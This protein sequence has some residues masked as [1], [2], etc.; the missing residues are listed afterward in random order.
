MHVERRWRSGQGL[1]L[2]T[3]LAS[4]S[5]TGS[6]AWLAWKSSSTIIG[7]VFSRLTEAEQFILSRDGC[8]KLE[9]GLEIYRIV[10]LRKHG[11]KTTPAEPSLAP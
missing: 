10:L 4:Q 8:F 5:S 1:G 6:K 7:F 9:I 2:G 11:W 3:G